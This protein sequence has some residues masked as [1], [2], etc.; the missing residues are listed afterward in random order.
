MVMVSPLRLPMAMVIPTTR[1]N[2]APLDTSGIFFGSTAVS[3]KSTK[4][5][6]RH[7]TGT[8]DL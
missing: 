2:T 7:V 1:V 4:V 8:I 5:V 6:W 3:E